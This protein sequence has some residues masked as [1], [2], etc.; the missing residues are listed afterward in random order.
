MGFQEVE[1]ARKSYS[2]KRK[3]I[4][5]KISFFAIPISV[6]ILILV[7][8]LRFGSFLLVLSS[9]ISVFILPM[10]LMVMLPII[11]ILGMINLAVYLIIISVST[12]NELSE[13]Q[14]LYKAY[15]VAESFKKVFTDISYSHEAALA[16]EIVK[17]VMSTG[18]KYYSN[19][20]MTA[21][22][23]N[24]GFTQADVRI[25]VESKSDDGPDYVVTFKGRFLVFDF[26]RNFASNL[27]VSSKSFHGEI[28][29]STN[30]NRK[31]ERIKTESN[32]FNKNFLIYAQDGVDA[33][34]I[35]DPAFMEKIQ[36]LYN[37]YN[38][39]LLL[40]FMD[41]K[42]YIAIN[43]WKDSFEI[44]SPNKPLNEAAELQKVQQDIFVITNFV[45]GLK[46]DKY[47]RGGKK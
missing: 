23:K 11:F 10:I 44:P 32:E 15:F 6:G 7:A 22:Y 47:F 18:D 39:P 14:K 1:N 17:Q 21:K 9:E 46:L 29:P 43:D 3:K 25:E 8:A 34:Y 5:K 37:Y 2:E 12:K 41:K 19:D 16:P 26:D 42:V 13:Y 31:F 45:D 40:T 4:A 27:Q 35:L 38:R 30:N 24:I 20:L 28:L 36:N 33:L